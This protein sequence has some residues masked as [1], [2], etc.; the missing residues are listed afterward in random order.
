MIDGLSQNPL[1]AAPAD[2]LGHP[3]GPGAGPGAGGR[4]VRPGPR[5]APA[6]VP[7]R[8]VRALRRPEGLGRAGPRDALGRP[9]GDRRRRLPAGRARSTR[10][11]ALVDTEAAPAAVVG[12]GPDAGRAGRAASQGPDPPAA[13]RPAPVGDRRGRAGSGRRLAAYPFPYRSAFNLR[14]DLDEPEPEDYARFARARRPIDDCST[15]FVSTGA[16]GDLPGRPRRPPAGRRPVARALP[17]RL[18]RARG[19]PPEPGAGPPRSWSTP[20]SRPRGSPGLTGGGTRGSTR[21]SRT[22]ATRT[23]PTSSS[24]TTTCRSSPGG[25]TGSRRSCRSR[26][27]RSARGS[28]SRPGATGRSVADHLVRAV[29]AKVEAG[30]PAFVYGHPERRLGRY[31]EIVSRAGRGG[32][33]RVAALADDAHRV[34]P[35][36]AVA[37]RAGA[38]RSSPAGEGRFEVQFDEWDAALPARPWRS[39]GAGTSRSIPLVGPEDAVRAR[40]PGLR[41]P[42]DPGRP[43]R[44]VDPPGPPGL[45]AAV[46]SALDW[47]TVTPIEELPA[48]TIAARVKRELRRWKDREAAGR[49]RRDGSG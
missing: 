10:S 9:R 42:G 2:A 25:A 38:G 13:D 44:A 19:E 14:V 31:P 8:P 32:R 22:W 36:V 11:A 46:R 7:G 4:P 6:G 39:S 49:R 1:P 5:P 24:A 3:A 17:L 26:S 28:S 40:R 16:Y 35:L 27:T 48:G 33:A 12:R 18:P 20:G 30:E 37:G 47:E 41:A 43:P 15:H 29:R 21:S 23:R 34:R 45:K